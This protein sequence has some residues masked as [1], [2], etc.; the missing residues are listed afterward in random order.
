MHETGHMWFPMQVG[1]N[2]TRNPWMD[3]GFTQFDVAQAMRALYGEP[4]T[5]GRP[6]DS[7][8]GQRALYLASARRGAEAPLMLPGDEYPQDLYLVMYYDK[9]AQALVAL[10]SIVGA[11]AFHAA[12]VDYGKHWIGR[13]P[14]PYDFF[15]AMARSTHRD[16]S[17]FWQT[18]FYHTWP[19]DQEVASV[20]TAMDS[21]TV[22]VRDRGL[23]PMPVRLAVTRADGSVQ[24]VE[25]PVDAW[26]AGVRTATVRV[27]AAPAVVKV[28]IDP[29]QAFPY[30][31]RTGLTWT[32]AGGGGGGGGGR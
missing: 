9:T 8:A 27:A 2:E 10:R 24:R 12:F 5:G 17:W 11:D 28:E 15:N 23:A 25:I 18:W 14:Q 19:L 29:A 6:N 22:T 13:H 30:V 4:R 21:T 20:T 3:E 31:D 26:L 32:A 7:E 16:L 1:S